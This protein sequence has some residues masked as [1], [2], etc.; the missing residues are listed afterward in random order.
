LTAPTTTLTQLLR[1]IAE[2]LGEAVGF[3]ALG[4]TTALGSTST[5]V[6]AVRLLF[7]G[8][9]ADALGNAVVRFD[10]GVVSAYAPAAT[11]ATGIPNATDLAVVYASAGDP[12][13]LNDV[14]QIENEQMRVDVVNAGTNTLTVT[15]GYA[16]TV[17]VP[18]MTT[19]VAI[20]K[21]NNPLGGQWATVTDGGLTPATGAVAFSPPLGAA[22]PAGIDYS[23]WRDIHPDQAKK[24]LMRALRRF[25]HEVLVPV[26]IAPDGDMEDTGTG[27]YSAV[28]ATLSKQIA[29]TTPERDFIRH[30]AQALKIVATADN[31]GAHSPTLITAKAVAGDQWIA[32]V[33]M[34]TATLGSGDC[35]FRVINQDSGAVI[36]SA[37]HGE[38]AY[39]EMFLQAITVPAG[40]ERLRMELLV[41]LNGQTAYADDAVFWPVN[42]SRFVL[43]TWVDDP[44]DVIEV[45][46]W[47]L[48]RALAGSDVYMVDE[49]PWT[50]WPF[51]LR[52]YYAE[53]QAA[54]NYMLELA[55]PVVRPLFVRIRRKHS[56]LSAET[57]TTTADRKLL[58]DCAMIEIY[59]GLEADAV[60]NGSEDQARLWAR[61]R[62]RLQDDAAVRAFL[63]RSHE[64]NLKVQAPR[65]RTWRGPA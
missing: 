31:G 42:R 13:A 9:D 49:T 3:P 46:Y 53:E 18:H 54:N 1:D 30:G 47:P 16:Q 26:S 51:T 34:R 19:G 7:S 57:D 35:L 28:N 21:I 64:M 40:C 60:R 29:G 41:S 63:G 17:P 58:V 15:R 38:T 43:P 45:G 24:A 39:Q 48:G 27:E 22:V 61:L 44:A 23:L 36:A 62:N 59:E 37:Q 56:E 55:T 33:A 5:F 8:A 14:I 4:Q 50:P 2:R 65:R 10:S 32:S 25:D 52:P 6:D 12:I 20:Y 11:L